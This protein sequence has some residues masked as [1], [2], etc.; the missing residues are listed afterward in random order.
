MTPGI[1]LQKTPGFR[2]FRGSKM[3]LP[4]ET[5]KIFAALDASNHEEVRYSEFLAAMM[6]SRIEIHEDLVRAAFK[7]LRAK[8]NLEK[9]R[10]KP[11]FPVGPNKNVFFVC[12]F[13][14]WLVGWLGK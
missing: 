13:V 10:E 3:F 9:H 11:I 7:R 12:L 6:S 14:G 1:R 5:R 8:K 2:D 4:E